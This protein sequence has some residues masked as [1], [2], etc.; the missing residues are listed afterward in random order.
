MAGHGAGVPPVLSARLSDRD[1][2]LGVA[3]DQWPWAA[4]G[5]GTERGPV[6]AQTTITLTPVLGHTDH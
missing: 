3:G 4:A 1:C 6:T 5:A 2:Q